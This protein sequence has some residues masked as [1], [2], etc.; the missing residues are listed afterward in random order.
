MPQ[1]PRLPPT[2]KPCS[3]V[4]VGMRVLLTGTGSRPKQRRPLPT[5]VRPA[6]RRWC[7]NHDDSASAGSRSS[8]AILPCLP[9]TPY[10]DK[11]TLIRGLYATQV[12][13]RGC[14][15]AASDGDLHSPPALRWGPLSRLGCTIAPLPTACGQSVVAHTAENTARQAGLPA[16]RASTG[17]ESGCCR[18]IHSAGE[19]TLFGL[20]VGWH[21]SNAHDDRWRQQYG[22]PTWGRG[23]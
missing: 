11:E 16:E 17:P 22:A 19:A 3:S 13:Q 2:G 12:P 18:H 6:T 21:M 9:G 15:P 10:R 5:C 4:R 1:Q 14:E 8:W 7:G 20:L 23:L